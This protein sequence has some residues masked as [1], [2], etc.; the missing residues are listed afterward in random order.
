MA[1]QITLF[2]DV[3]LPLTLGGE[4]SPITVAYQTYGRLN[5]EKSNAV[6]LCHALTGDAKPY[7]DSPTEKGWWQDFI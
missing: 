3:P 4:L 5:A 2:E 7:Y 6:L 1:Q